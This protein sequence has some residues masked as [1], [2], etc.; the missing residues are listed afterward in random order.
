MYNHVSE[1]LQLQVSISVAHLETE[2]CAPIALSK[3]LKLSQ[4]E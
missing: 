2:I 3:Q 4:N 1:Q